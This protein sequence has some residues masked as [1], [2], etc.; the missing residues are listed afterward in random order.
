MRMSIPII[1]CVLCGL[2]SGCVAKRSVTVYVEDRRVIEV[3][4][5]GWFVLGGEWQT[6][7]DDKCVTDTRTKETIDSLGLAAVG[8]AAGWLVK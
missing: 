6:V 1:L 3:R 8:V 4:E 5:E 2:L 7:I